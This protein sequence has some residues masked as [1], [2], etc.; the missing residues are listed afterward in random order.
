M[1]KN[2][3]KPAASASESRSPFFWLATSLGYA[4]A[5]RLLHDGRWFHSTARDDMR[6]A[7]CRWPRVA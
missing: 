5:S 1:V 4:L 3:S 7:L 6:P 2:T